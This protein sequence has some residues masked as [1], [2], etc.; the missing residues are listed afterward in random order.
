MNDEE[1]KSRLQI[2]SDWKAEA[3][4]EKERLAREEKPAKG[5]AG[6]AG[7]AAAT[8]F[9]ELVNL[10]AMQAAIALGGYQDPSGTRIPPNPAA[11]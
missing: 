7:A 8:S 4:N 10:L 5:S 3:A 2:D 1:S 9:I 11:A 6:A